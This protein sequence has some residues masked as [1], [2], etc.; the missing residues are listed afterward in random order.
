[1][2]PFDWKAVYYQSASLYAGLLHRFWERF[3][4]RRLL[5]RRWH[6]RIVVEPRHD[7]PARA[8]CAAFWH[9]HEGTAQEAAA[10]FEHVRDL[11]HG[12]ELYANAKAFAAALDSESLEQI[13]DWRPPERPAG[14][15]LRP[16]VRDALED[17]GTIARDIALVQRSRSAR[18]RSSALNRASGAL[19]GLWTAREMEART[20][21]QGE[22]ASGDAPQQSLGATYGLAGAGTRTDRPDRTS[23]AGDRLTERRRSRVTG[24]AGAGGEPLHC[25]RVCAR[26][27]DGRPPGHL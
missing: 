16:E 4:L 20:P 22:R 15:L 26:R 18:Q 27:A 24:G 14:E 5:P 9:L 11:P 8:A 25:R 2:D 19:R 23:V 21:Q 6:P 17:L 3:L 13:A 10:A 12:E 1:M 7:T